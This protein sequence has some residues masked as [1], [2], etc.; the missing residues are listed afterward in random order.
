MW[1]YNY[2]DRNDWLEHGLLSRGPRTNHK[3]I[4]RNFIGGRWVYQYANNAKNALHNT[5]KS[6]R[7]TVARGAALRNDRK[8]ATSQKMN[9]GRVIAGANNIAKRAANTGASAMAKGEATL[10]KLRTNAA[11][12]RK[13]Q[14]TVNIQNAKN[15]ARAKSNTTNNVARNS[16]P[17][18][19][20][21][22]SP[23]KQKTSN[24][25][26]NA[27]NNAK[28]MTPNKKKKKK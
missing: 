26:Q 2:S 14:T 5:Q 27:K 20:N 7:R 16:T 21:L 8:L 10:N 15:V 28:G 4:S 23:S 24:D 13:T 6:L 18:P 22:G 11:A 1:E 25:V 17:A 19:A 9:V 3:Y 12:R